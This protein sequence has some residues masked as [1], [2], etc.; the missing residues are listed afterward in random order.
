MSSTAINAD[1][2]D[3]KQE[4][5]KNK[6]IR[7]KKTMPKGKNKTPKGG[8]F[9]LTNDQDDWQ[10]DE[11]IKKEADKHSYGGFLK[12]ILNFRFMNLLLVSFSLFVTIS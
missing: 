1:E 5:P 11:M 9:F 7:I 8:D 6:K 12:S 10:L 3:L 2:V 4:K